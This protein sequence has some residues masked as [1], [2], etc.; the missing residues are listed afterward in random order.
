MPARSRE[1][2]S[3]AEVRAHFRR[4]LAAGHLPG[5]LHPI[6]PSAE[7][8]PIET[9]LDLL[10]RRARSEDEDG[11][12]LAK[13]CD[14]FGEVELEVAR[15]SADHLGLAHRTVSHDDRFAVID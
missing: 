15:R 6:D 1:S 13:S 7:S 9:S 5:R 3:R 11:I 8:A 2:E 14:D 12:G 10:F 4:D